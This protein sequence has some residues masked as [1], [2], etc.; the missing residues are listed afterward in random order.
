MR[1]IKINMNRLKWSNYFPEYPES[2]RWVV[3]WTRVMEDIAREH[4]I[5]VCF[6]T[7]GN[8]GAVTAIE[9]EGFDKYES[10]AID[11]Y[12]TEEYQWY[13]KASGVAMKR[14]DTIDEVLKR[15]EIN[16]TPTYVPKQPRRCV[17]YEAF[18]NHLPVVGTANDQID[19]VR[20]LQNEALELLCVG[21]LYNS[22]LK[23]AQRL[24]VV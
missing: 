18:Y 14:L 7:G 17:T 9:I 24:G 3:A 4:E 19:A 2:D 1:T 10:S 20:A 11:F 6:L 8:G 12:L 21:D 5:D 13:G 23:L 16:I 15:C 22:V